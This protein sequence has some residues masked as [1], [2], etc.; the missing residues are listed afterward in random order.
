MN[1]LHQ[2][3]S[4]LE[5]LDR[6]SISQGV[7]QQFVAVRMVAK[8]TVVAGN[9]EGLLHLALQLLRLGSKVAPGSH[10]HLDEASVAD[11][12]ETNVVFVYEEAPW[13]ESNVRTHDA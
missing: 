9:R 12:A 11:I 6:A 13:Q 3:I 1:D 7:S 2:V 4:S 8:E 5:E 10:Y